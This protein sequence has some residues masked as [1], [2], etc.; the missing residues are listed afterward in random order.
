M[1]GKFTRPRLKILKHAFQNYTGDVTR[2]L[3]NHQLKPGEDITKDAN[4]HIQVSGQV[5]VME[6]NA[7]L[8]KTIFEKNPK[9]EFYIEESFPLDWMYPY[10]EPHGLIMKIN[11]QPLAELSDEIVRRDRDYW[12]N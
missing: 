3:K 11:R 9:Q 10:L 4:G 12:A 2:R 7:L 5:A 8:V 1:A 6:I